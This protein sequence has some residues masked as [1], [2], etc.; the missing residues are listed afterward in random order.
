MGEWG[1]KG[2]GDGK[3]RRYGGIEVG[4]GRG[5]ERGDGGRGGEGGFVG[6]WSEGR[7]GDCYGGFSC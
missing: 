4:R 3:D 5:E 1:R 2:N 7:G 6:N